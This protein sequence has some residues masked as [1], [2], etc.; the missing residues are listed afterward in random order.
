MSLKKGKQTQ[1]Q[2]LVKAVEQQYPESTNCILW[3]FHISVWGYGRVYHPALKRQASAHRA[4]YELAS[5][6]IPEGLFV[7]HRCDVRACINPA[8]LFLGTPQDNMDDKVAKGRQSKLSG[9]LAGAA[10]LKQHQVDQMYRLYESGYTEQQIGDMFGVGRENV[11]CII[12][13]ET[14]PHRHPQN[15][16]EHAHID[17]STPRRMALAGERH[18]RAKNRERRCD[19]N[20]H[21]AKSGENDKR[22]CLG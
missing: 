17:L 22:D 3:P 9:E 13:G 20:S 11:S 19:P 10:H 18:G 7:C 5:A 21:T 6:P 14:W 12:R 2:W 15:C 4:A 8:H 16:P 1:Y